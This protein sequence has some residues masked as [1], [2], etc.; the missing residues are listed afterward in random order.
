MPHPNLAP[1]DTLTSITPPSLVDDGLSISRRM[2]RA[3]HR[4]VNSW[5]QDT[6]D[7]IAPPVLPPT[8]ATSDTLYTG[9][10]VDDGADMHY[11]AA[12]S[13]IPGC[14]IVD[15][16]F[17]N[18]GKPRKSAYEEWTV[19]KEKAL[20]GDMWRSLAKMRS[21]ARVEV[22]EASE[23]ERKEERKKRKERGVG[24]VG[25]DGRVRIMKPLT[26]GTFVI[27]GSDGRVVVVDKEGEYDSGRIGEREEVVRR[28][29]E[30]EEMVARRKAKEEEKIERE[31]EREAK[32]RAVVEAR[33]RREREE[34]EK[35]KKRAG[36]Q[37][38]EK[39][40]RRRRH[41][42]SSR[43]LTPIPEADTPEE[44]ATRIVSPTKFFMTGAQSER[45]STNYRPTK[46]SVVPP[47]PLKS[48]PGVWP[49]PQL[50]PIKSVQPARST[51]SPTALSTITPVTKSD[52]VWVEQPSWAPEASTVRL[53]SSASSGRYSDATSSTTSGAAPQGYRSPKR[54]WIPEDK[55][56]ECSS[57]KR[58]TSVRRSKAGSVGTWR[59]NASRHPILSPPKRTASANRSRGRSKDTWT[60]D[61]DRQPAR[62]ISRRRKSRE[63]SRTR[64]KGSW[65]RDVDGFE[66]R[67][68]RRASRSPTKSSMASVSAWIQDDSDRFTRSV[69]SPSK[70]V[71]SRVSVSSRNQMEHR[72]R[73]PSVRSQKSA[74][75]RTSVVTPYSWRRQVEEM[76]DHSTAGSN[77]SRSRR[78]SP[79]PSHD[80]GSDGEA[81]AGQD[82]DTRS[83]KSHSTYRAPT[84][85]DAADSEDGAQEWD[86]AWSVKDG[87]KGG[88]GGGD[89][90]S[91]AGV[92]G[93]VAGS[94][95]WSG[96]TGW[97]GHVE[98][99]GGVAEGAEGSDWKDQSGYD[100]G[101]DTWLN[102]EVGGV[103]YREAEWRRDAPEGSWRDV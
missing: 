100:E 11:P 38:K 54:S 93:S 60:E 58:A 78:P 19:E 85:E 48:P 53:P 13:I 99:P 68:S 55:Q 63:A 66:P 44:S 23:V 41:R 24:A 69:Y 75:S 79:I 51:R 62:A 86:S 97:G 29:R 81:V 91:E 37:R 101:N 36:Q 64:S 92:E 2:P 18:K 22:R 70:S 16:A 21:I 96:K 82:E 33:E 67:V 47:S 8:S 28:E 40:S 59:D 4:D 45:S 14:G 95:R 50:S 3:G 84:V 7:P 65:Q 83:V 102:S 52:D 15:R 34:A 77:G 10:F 25:D 42:S 76:S 56:S 30:Y 12:M 89:G 72:G 17:Y 98:T 80:R 27:E 31:R 6:P 39:H 9:S 32:A 94:G 71:T 1:S 61:V 74:G 43:L 73:A 103:K 26:W 49:A 57:S 5:L 35:A 90:E 88:D 46:L 20:A 87:Q